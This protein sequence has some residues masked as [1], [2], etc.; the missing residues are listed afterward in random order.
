MRVYAPVINGEELDASGRAL[1]PAI[2]PFNEAAWA[3]VAQA[4]SAD[5]DDAVGCAEDTFRRTWR[6]TTGVERA[7]LLHR[8]ADVM[9][10]QSERLAG[11]ETTDNGK[12]IRETRTQ[13]RYAARI[14]RF[15]A[16]LADKLTG[17]TKPLDNLNTF[18]YTTREPVGVAALITAWNSPLLLLSYK[19]APALAAGNTVVVKASE[20]TSVSTLEFMQLVEEAGFPRGVINVVTG[21]SAVGRALAGHPSVNKVSFT[22]SIN[23]GRDVARSA[24]ANVV[25]VTLELGGKSANIIFPDADLKR[26]IPGVL[27][28]IFAAAGQTCVA[29]SRLVVH[30]DIHDDVVSAVVER[31]GAIVLGNPLDET[32]EMGPVAHKGQLESILTA[33]ERASA[34]G[35]ELLAGGQRAGNQPQGLFVEPT[36]FGGVANDMALAQEEIFGPVLAVLRFE[37]EAE[38][39]AIANGTKYGLAAG[40]WTSD[41]ARVHRVSRELESGIVWVNTYRAGGAQV[42]FGGVKRS[43]YGRERGVESIN[44]YLRV[45]NTMIDLG[46]EARDPFSVKA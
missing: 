11:L 24:A 3:E 41:V 34:D 25:P 27:A 4:T 15:F 28:G 42:P 22:G 36:V 21:A 35:A 1:V 46:G 16:G 18:D 32:T 14:Y 26:A 29:G 13:M 33:I 43:G 17:D 31:S 6:K 39:I 2:D 7:R 20:H 38:A 37:D 10:R 44:D 9:D 12:V 8:L 45:K 23:A 5:V 19:L 40:I 30:T